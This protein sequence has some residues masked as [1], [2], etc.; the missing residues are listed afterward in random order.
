MTLIRWTS[1]QAAVAWVCLCLALPATAQEHRFSF[2]AGRKGGGFDGLAKTVQSALVELDGDVQVD[3]ENTR[4]SCDNIKKLLKGELDFALVQ[5]DVAVE[6]WLATHAARPDGADAGEADGSKQTGWMCRVSATLAGSV[7]LRLVGAVQSE[8]VHLLV[9]RPIHVSDMSELQDQ[10]VY[11]GRDGSGSRETARV[12][13]GAAGHPLTDFDLFAE[14]SGAARKA[15]RAGELLAML[16]T[17]EPGGDS[18]AKLVDSGVAHVNPLPED[19]LDALIDNHRYYRVC[20]IDPN[21]YRGLDHAVPTVCV[22]TVILTA[23]PVGAGPEVEARRAALSRGTE[24]VLNALSQ[25]VESP[26]RN[27]P[28]IHLTWDDFAEETPIPLHPKAEALRARLQRAEWLRFAMIV[29]IA[30]ALMAAFVWIRRRLRGQK[31]GIRGAIEGNL[32]N[33]LVPFMGFTL[34]VMLATAVVWKLEHE[35]NGQIRTQWE[36][37]WAMVMFATGNFES[38]M[39]KTFGAKFIGAGGTL[40][41]LGFLAWFTAALTTMLARDRG[42]FWRR[43]KDHV[44]VVNFREEMLPMLR[45]LRAPGPLRVPALHLILADTLPDRVHHQLASIKGVTIHRLHPEAPADLAVLRLDRARRVV[46][47]ETG[48]DGYHPVRIARAIHG[49]TRLGSGAAP[50]T[51]RAIEDGNAHAGAEDVARMQVGSQSNRR[52]ADRHPWTL[53]ETTSDEPDAMFDPF[54]RWVVPVQSRML[55]DRWMVSACRTPLFPEIYDRILSFR[56]GNSEVYTVSVPEWCQGKP[57]L[58]VRRALLA[59]RGEPGV[60]PLGLH[61]PREPPEPGRRPWVLLVN[62]PP[63]E[64]VQSGDRLIALAEDEADLVRLVRR[65]RKVLAKEEARLKAK[66]SGG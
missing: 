34:L 31:E 4:G 2:G 46:V 27:G 45:M 3:V 40:F 11:A 39:L 12:I 33:P 32:G 41:G 55:V 59:T 44:I 6:A 49:A 42:L 28:R 18:V 48:D 22:A 1:G 65:S 29:V 57:W 8:A 56:T 64:R 23:I 7:Q 47:L 25:L 24:E 60:I 54:G 16:V 63:A 38:D 50:S 13:F 35:V 19:V 58:L 10:V 17:E 21:T 36:A 9:R 52:A 37:F 26:P 66:A 30:F 51:G 43:L 20:Q 14:G 53:M 62:P 61:R 15:M 5:Y